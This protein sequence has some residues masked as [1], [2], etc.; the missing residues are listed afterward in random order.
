M[1]HHDIEPIQSQLGYP[2]KTAPQL[3]PIGVAVHRCHWSECFEVGQ[4]PGIAHVARVQDMIDPGEG[5][6]HL[7]PKQPMRI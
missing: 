5:I 4:D 2:G 3:G 7:G 6:E 1:R